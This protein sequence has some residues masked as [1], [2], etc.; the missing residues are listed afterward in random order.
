[1]SAEAE[2]PDVGGTVFD[3]HAVEIARSYAQAFLNL[4]EE[5]Q[6]GEPLLAELEELIADVWHAEP[7]FATLLAG[8]SLRA[9]RREELLGEILDG[10]ADELLGRFV[11]VV[12][13]RGRLELLPQIAREARVYWDRRHRIVEVEVTSA[14]PLDEAHKAAILERLGVAMPGRTARL[15]T[16]IDPDILGGLVLQIGDRMLDA[17]VRTRL[18]KVRDQML[19]GRQREIKGRRDEL[20]SGL[21]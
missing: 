1:M 11:R 2:T 6:R 3:T 16:K 13:R 4:V 9:E 19:M 18:R 10:R 12:N 8:A 5:G 14:V 17:S 21:N 20:A 15:S 7:E